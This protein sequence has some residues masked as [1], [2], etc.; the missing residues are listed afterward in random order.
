M[1]RRK[2]FFLLALLTAVLLPSSAV[3]DESDDP[4]HYDPSGQLF[5][6]PDLRNGHEPT[7]YEKYSDSGWNYDY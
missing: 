2:L 6:S 3:A 5:E 4:G 7:L 1:N